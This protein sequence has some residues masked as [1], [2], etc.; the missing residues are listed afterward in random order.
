[1]TRN[2]TIKTPSQKMI[3]VFESLREK[4]QQQMKKLDENKQCTFTL[5]V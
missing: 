4:T 1:M 3:Q 2:I 5:V